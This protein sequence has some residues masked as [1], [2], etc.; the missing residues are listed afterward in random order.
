MSEK[1][2]QRKLHT[3]SGATILLALLFFLLCAV[4]GSAVLAAGTAASGRIAGLT[5]RQQAYYS[6]TSAARLIRDEI[7]GQKVSVYKKRDDTTG[8]LYY[9]EEPAGKWKEL[10]ETL[11]AQVTADSDKGA[12]KSAY[13]IITPWSGAKADAVEAEIT[14]DKDYNLEIQLQIDDED[15]YACTI[16]I[17]AAVAQKA[18]ETTALDKETLVT[19]QTTSFVWDNAV[20]HKAE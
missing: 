5:D 13:V 19:I 3:T 11:A 15:A 6:V 8:T 14:I 7:E 2:L 9:K 16:T 4:A 20:I 12:Y 1:T 17:P 10:L 18:Q